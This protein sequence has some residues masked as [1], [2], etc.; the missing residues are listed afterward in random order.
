M[1]KMPMLT[2]YES[3]ITDIKQTD[4]YESVGCSSQDQVEVQ[5]HIEINRWPMKV[6]LYD[7]LHHLL[8]YN[9]VQLYV[10]WRFAYH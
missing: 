4:F 10:Q 2:I 3:I 9:I 5:S 6:Q 7:K 8:K 1:L